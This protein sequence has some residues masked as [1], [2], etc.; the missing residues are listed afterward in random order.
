[1]SFVANEE[2]TEADK[3]VTVSVD[4]GKKV[5][6]TRSQFL[7]LASLVDPLDRAWIVLQAFAGLRPEE[8]APKRESVKRGL[9]IEDIDW[10]FKVLRVPDEVSKTVASVIPMSDCLIAWLNWAGIKEGMGGPCCVRNP[11]EER[12]T[13]RLGKLIFE[14]SGWPKDALR[15]SYGS[16]RNALLRNLPQ[17][18]EEMRTSVTML[19]RHY[20]TPRAQEEGEAWFSMR[21]GDPICSDEIDLQASEFA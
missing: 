12:E 21:P 8:A 17:L 16:Y 18:A 13:T 11:A 1:M 4:S 6:W 10:R 15:H 19:N 5:I 3:L 9:Q 14:S 7:K 2:V 20:H